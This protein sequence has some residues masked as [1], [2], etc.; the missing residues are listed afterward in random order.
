MVE[1]TINAE[2]VFVEI[3]DENGSRSTA[4][5]ASGFLFTDRSGEPE[6]N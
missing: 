3:V 2:H 5:I 4:A 6:P 1:N